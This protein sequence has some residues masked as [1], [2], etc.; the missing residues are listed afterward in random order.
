[1]PFALVFV[2]LQSMKNNDKFTIDETYGERLLISVNADQTELLDNIRVAR[3]L[4]GCF[5]DI[6]RN[7]K[8]E[9]ITPHELC[10]QHK[11]SERSSLNFAL[12]ANCSRPLTTF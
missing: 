4:L 9:D 2:T 7:R 10:P 1:M 12:K 8:T 3:V 11:Q 6:R 5:E